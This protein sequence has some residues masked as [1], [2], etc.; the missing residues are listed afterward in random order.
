MRLRDKME[1]A[2]QISQHAVT[3]RKDT[4][5]QV[6]ETAEAVA[7]GRRRTEDEVCSVRRQ[8]APIGIAELDDCGEKRIVTNEVAGR[9][10]RIVMSGL[11]FATETVSRIAWI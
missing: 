11:N 10:D 7:T 3:L 2:I 8:I 6:D 1:R 5:L 4:S 9:L